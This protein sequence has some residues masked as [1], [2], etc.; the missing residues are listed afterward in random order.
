MPKNE[1]SVA[2]TGRGDVDVC[3]F[4][5]H[6]LARRNV[7]IYALSSLAHLPWT[8]ISVSSFAHSLILLPLISLSLICPLSPLSLSMRPLHPR[9]CLCSLLTNAIAF[10]QL[11]TCSQLSLSLNSLIDAHLLALARL[12][13]I[14]LSHCPQ[15]PARLP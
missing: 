10:S 13:E 15:Q 14:S 4:C 1:I 8:H 3:Y 5:V 11:S 9:L 6:R 2:L 7:I 12:C